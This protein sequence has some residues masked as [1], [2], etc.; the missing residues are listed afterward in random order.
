MSEARAAAVRNDELYLL[1]CWMPA[2]DMD[3]RLMIKDMAGNAE[4]VAEVF[5]GERH[6]ALISAAPQML[7]LLRSIV[8]DGLLDRRE[9]RAMEVLQFATEAVRW[10]Q[11]EE[12]A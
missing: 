3:G 1:A 5:A 9:S 7:R 10:A 12:I 2:S 8:D 4:P 6:A 11:G